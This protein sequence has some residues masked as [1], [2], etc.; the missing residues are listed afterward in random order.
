MVKCGYG[1]TGGCCTNVLLHSSTNY[2]QGH[3]TEPFRL[4]KDV[5]AAC[6]AVMFHFHD[7]YMVCD[8]ST[9]CIQS[10]KIQ[11]VFGLCAVLKCVK[12]TNFGCCVWGYVLIENIKQGEFVCCVCGDFNVNFLIFSSSGSGRVTRVG[13]SAGTLHRTM[14]VV[15]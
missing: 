7:V 3:A 15:P 6:G 12:G 4:P 2:H 13:S 10:V 5:A 1:K 11:F 9:G 14:T 8:V